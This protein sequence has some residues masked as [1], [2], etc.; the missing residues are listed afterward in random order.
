[1]NHQSIFES[2][3]VPKSFTLVFVSVTGRL[4]YSANQT[5]EH[6]TTQR[7]QEGS[8]ISN[9]IKGFCHTAEPG[10]MEPFGE[11]GEYLL[12]CNQRFDSEE[13]K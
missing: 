3:E 12:I 9:E 8:Q 5:F 10:F 13:A 4:C 2:S 11:T 6:L 7:F 1:M